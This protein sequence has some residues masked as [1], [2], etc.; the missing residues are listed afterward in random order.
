MAKV[1]NGIEQTAKDTIVD[2]FHHPVCLRVIDTSLSIHGVAD[3]EPY[4]SHHN[5]ALL[6]CLHFLDLTRKGAVVK[7]APVHVGYEDD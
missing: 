1:D 5:L 7:R 2:N 3:I 6:C 4:I